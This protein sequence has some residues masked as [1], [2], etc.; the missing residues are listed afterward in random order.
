MPYVSVVFTAGVSVLVVLESGVVVL[1]SVVVVLETG[2]T[3]LASAVVGLVS[4]SGPVLFVCVAFDWVL[5]S[6]G[7]AVAVSVLLIGVLL[8]GSVG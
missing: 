4:V 3:V 7:M 2:V 1:E 5:A 8:A 6:T